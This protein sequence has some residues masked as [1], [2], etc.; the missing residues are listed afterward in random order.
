M[1][2]ELDRNEVV[3]PPTKNSCG[4]TQPEGPIEQ[5]ILFISRGHLNLALLK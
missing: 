2:C 3:I 5:H 4:N 1:V